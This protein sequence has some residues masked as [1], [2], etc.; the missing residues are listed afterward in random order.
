MRRVLGPVFASAFSLYLP[1]FWIQKQ[2]GG[3]FLKVYYWGIRFPLR[4]SLAFTR[5]RPFPSQTRRLEFAFCSL[6]RK[7]ASTLMNDVAHRASSTGPRQSYLAAARE[8]A[9]RPS[10]RRACL[11]LPTVRKLAFLAAL[12]T[13]GARVFVRQSSKTPGALE[14]GMRRC[15]GGLRDGWCCSCDCVDAS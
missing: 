1:Q 13:R 15:S 10:D 9:E 5:T 8:V 4:P 11:V 14:L 3:P 7:P 12:C 6:P 2:G